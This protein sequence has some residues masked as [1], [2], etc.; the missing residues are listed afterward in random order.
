M[1]HDPILK[2]IIIWMLGLYAIYMVEHSALMPHPKLGVQGFII[3]AALIS[4]YMTVC[5][6]L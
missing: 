1:L 6:R 5:H 4:F 3:A 2:L